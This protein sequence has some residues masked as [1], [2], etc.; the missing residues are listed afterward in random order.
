M[1]ALRIDHTA[2]PHT[3]PICHHRCTLRPLNPT[4][5][6]PGRPAKRP[7]ELLRLLTEEAS[8]DRPMPLD[9]VAD[10]LDIDPDNAKQIIYRAR[11]TRPEVVICN[12]RGVGYY[13][14]RP[15]NT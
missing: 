15:S 4:P 8:A 6:P 14:I 5:N 12:V 3:C 13:A 9:T 11:Q 7:E 1:P 2:G 10:R